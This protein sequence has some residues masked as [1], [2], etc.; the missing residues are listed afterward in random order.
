[1]DD[2]EIRATVCDL[3][4]QR[5]VRADSERTRGNEMLDKDIVE[6]VLTKY[7]KNNNIKYK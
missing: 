1:L 5:V 2:E 3:E 4:N 6:L 7:C